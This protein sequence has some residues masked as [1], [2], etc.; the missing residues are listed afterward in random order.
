M[1]TKI[2]LNSIINNLNIVKTER[3]SHL[4]ASI[5]KH[6][7][8]NHIRRNP[9]LGYDSSKKE[10]VKNFYDKLANSF[11][12]ISLSGDRHDCYRHYESIG[13]GTIPISDIP[14]R[15]QN[16][17]GDSM[18]LNKTTQDIIDLIS[19]GCNYHYKEPNKDIITTKY[20][21]QF[22]LEKIY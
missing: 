3:L 17:F 18:I 13:L 15:Y 21:H 12:T 2:Y 9:K 22:F 11:F 19:N 6:L 1:G 20:W 16:I 5:H 14:T 8:K 10:P 4:F 7:P